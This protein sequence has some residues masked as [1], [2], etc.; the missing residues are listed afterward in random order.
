MSSKTISIDP[1]LFKI[2]GKKRKTHSQ[3]T[4]INSNLNINSNNIRQMLIEKLRKKRKTQKIPPKIHT[5]SFDTS[6]SI[7]LEPKLSVG[8]FNKPNSEST[9]IPVNINKFPETTTPT[10]TTFIQPD[11]PYG[12]LKNGTKPTYKTWSVS[13]KNYDEL[14]NNNNNSNNSNNNNNNSNNNNSNNNINN[15]NNS[16]NNSLIIPVI[17]IDSECSNETIKETPQIQH[18]EIKKTYMI[19][20]NKKSNSIGV[21]IKNTN[22]RKKIE[23]D[24]LKNKKTN[25]TTVK[26]F[27]KTHNMIKHGTTAPNNLLRTMYE[28]MKLCGDISN[29]NNSNLIHNFEKD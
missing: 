21:L 2:H 13:Q 27:L 22:T 20:K 18:R 15:S 14:V 1:Q 26:N 29:E 28:N 8:D 3:S 7:F 12:V 16:N 4:L 6:P 19:G 25:I 9:S 24:I 5:K 10:I 17:H 23:E 11:K